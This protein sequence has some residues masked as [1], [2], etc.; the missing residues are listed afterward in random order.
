VAREKKAYPVAVLC[1]IMGV[2][3]SGFYDYLKRQQRPP[4]R[5]RQTLLA[6]MKDIAEGSNYSYGS[7]RM[8]RA[9]Q[10]FGHRVGR[11]QTRRLMRDAGIVVR[12][13]KRYRVTTNSHHSEPVFPNRLQRD[14]EPAAPNR[15]WVADITYVWTR[16]GWLYLAVVLDLYSRSVVGWSLSRRM[17]STLVCDA[18]QMAIWR[19]RPQPGELIHHSDRGVQ[20]ASKPFRQ[21]LQQYGIHGSMSRKGDCW[22]NAVAESF[23]ATLKS[24]RIRWRSY[25]TREEAKRDIIDYIV[26]FYNSRRLH[27]YLDYQSPNDFERNGLLKKVA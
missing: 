21:L 16:E 23:F 10:A 7:R 1:R 9:L 5:E 4:D 20:Y 19:R 8:M 2:S 18:L 6:D 17:Q 13:R 3:R 14:F 12:Y 22:D 15:S 25:A 27:S 11:S 26:M 24:E